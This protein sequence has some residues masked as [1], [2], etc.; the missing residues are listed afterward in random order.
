MITPRRRLRKGFLRK[1]TKGS[2]H[3]SLTDPASMTQMSA[4]DAARQSWKG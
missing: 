1:K 2:I 4:T 3:S